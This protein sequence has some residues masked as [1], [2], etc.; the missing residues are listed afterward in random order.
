M[1]RTAGQRIETVDQFRLA[2]Y[3]ENCNG[4]QCGQGTLINAS[5]IAGA[6]LSKLILDGNR[7]GFRSDDGEL[8]EEPMLSFGGAGADRQVIEKCIVM[9]GRCS[10]GS[11]AIH[12]QEGGK[13]IVVPADDAFSAGADIWGNGRSA[14]ERPFGWGD[15]ISTASRN[16][17]DRE[18]PHLRCNRRRDHA[19]GRTRGH[20]CRAMPW[21]RCP[22]KCSA[23]SH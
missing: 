1:F 10:G 15:G 22:G 14:L 11:G 13:D 3:A 6:T 5:G 18:Q 8:V 12:V 19:A 21:L 4:R 16:T 17:F 7:Q 2:D 9:N 23:A 20:R